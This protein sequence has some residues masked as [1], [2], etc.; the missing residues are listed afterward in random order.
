MKGVRALSIAGTVR[1]CIVFTVP[2]YSALRCTAAACYLLH[3]RHSR[4]LMPP[5]LLYTLHVYLHFDT[6]TPAVPLPL[7]T[8]TTTTATTHHDTP[9]PQARPDKV[10]RMSGLP[11][12]ASPLAGA[13]ALSPSITTTHK[14]FLS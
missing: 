2:V 4:C 8:T 9:G 12:L 13:M 3:H 6:W 14:I 7:C 5:C 10:S 11:Y 1:H